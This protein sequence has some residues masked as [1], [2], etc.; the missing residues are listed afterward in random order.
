MV[1]DRLQL[2]SAAPLGLEHPRA[3]ERHGTML[4]QRSQVVALLCSEGVLLGEG[5]TERADHAPIDD[6]RYRGPALIAR[7]LRDTGE[8]RIAGRPGI[9]R[10]DPDR[11]PGPRGFR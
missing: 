4:S 2:G 1:G 6:E 9:W 8:Q 10:L 3:L 7:L 5:E 11:R